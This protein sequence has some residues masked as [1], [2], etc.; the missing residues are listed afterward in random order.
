MKIMGSLHLLSSAE[1]E[2]H[3]FYT[4]ASEQTF[5]V[6]S[7]N[8][9]NDNKIANLRKYFEDSELTNLHLFWY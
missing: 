1:D 4:Q 2:K 7:K 8:P 9:L 6:C 5:F 3:N